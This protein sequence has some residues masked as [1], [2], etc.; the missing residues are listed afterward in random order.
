MSAAVTSPHDDDDEDGLT[1]GD[2]G[3]LGGIDLVDAGQ[4]NVLL[5]T[6][7]VWNIIEGSLRLEGP[8]HQHVGV[9]TKHLQE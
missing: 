2:V 7:D 8:V 1:V 9:E 6:R 4:G 5:P 3:R